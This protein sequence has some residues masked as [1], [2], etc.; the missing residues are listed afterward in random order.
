M[1]KINWTLITKS[2]KKRVKKQHTAEFESCAAQIATAQKYLNMGLKIG[3]KLKFGTL[4]P[5][6]GG[7]YRVG[8]SGIPSPKET[9]IYLYFDEDSKIIYVVGMG[10]KEGQSKDINEAKKL[11]K[12]IRESK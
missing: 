2:Q 7:V 9:R 4:R 11:V 8:Q 3:G 5:E 1:W 10:F 12:I 6:S